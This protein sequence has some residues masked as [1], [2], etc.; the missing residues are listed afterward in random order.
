MQ[1]NR[2]IGVTLIAL[3]LVALAYQ[4]FTYTTREKAIDLGPLQVTTERTR[5]IPIPPIAG[6]LAL[7]GGVVILVLGSRRSV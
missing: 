1:K 2:A 4:G 3:G 7:M 5:K 6:A